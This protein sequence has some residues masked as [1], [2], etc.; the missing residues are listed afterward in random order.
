MSSASLKAIV[1]VAACTMAAGLVLLGYG[2]GAKSRN[3]QDSSNKNARPKSKG[4][5]T[6]SKWNP[7]LGNVVMIAPD[8]G[9]SVTGLKD[10]DD[11]EAR[12]SKSIENQL[13]GLRQIYRLEVE[14][15]PALMG[16][17]LLQLSVAPSGNVTQAKELRS[18]LTD[19]DFKKMILAEVSKWKFPEIGSD[20]ARINCP[21]LFVREGMD[22]NTLI[23]WERTLTFFEEQASLAHNAKATR[24]AGYSVVAA[25][26]EEGDA[27]PKKDVDSSREY[28]QK[29]DT[30]KIVGVYELRSPATVR[31]QPSFGAASLARVAP[32]TKVNVVAIYGDWLEIRPREGD[33]AGF[34]RKE[35]ATP[36]DKAKR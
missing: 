33:P 13:M 24:N 28:Q 18:H 2:A 8:L 7:A 34:I 9:F 5:K 25:R 17:I 15:K 3:G 21:L 32:G 22:I 30:K 1:V 11:R 29:S 4:E 19:Q 16:T 36:I 35:F 26:Q 20:A 6:E 23:Q 27:G 12:I 31:K 10:Q 14:K